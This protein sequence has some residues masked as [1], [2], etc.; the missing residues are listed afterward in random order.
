MSRAE[1]GGTRTGL[2]ATAINKIP[3][4]ADIAHIAQTNIENKGGTCSNEGGRES[5]PIGGTVARSEGL[6]RIIRK[7]G[8][9]SATCE[10]KPKSMSDGKGM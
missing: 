5:V 10:Y 8:N 3:T 2:T 6:A 4:P 7:V 1:R 9:Q